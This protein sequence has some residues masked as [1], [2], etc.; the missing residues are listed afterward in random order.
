M[1]EKRALVASADCG[2]D[3]A[4]AAALLARQRALH[5]ELRAHRAEIDALGAAARALSDRGIDELQVRAEW[6]TV[7]HHT[8]WR[9]Y[10]QAEI[11]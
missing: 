4:G 2:Q 10:Q 5:D 1:R 6:T 8:Q 9:S 11:G 3:A 7:P